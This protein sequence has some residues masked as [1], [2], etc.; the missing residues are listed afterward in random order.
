LTFK[1]CDV[2]LRGLTAAVVCTGS[3]R[4]VP[5]VG[6]H[7]P[8]VEPLAW[9]FMLRKNASEWEIESARAER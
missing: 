6:S 5:K 9:N 3:S 8:R 7:Q 4:Y 1:A 2:Q